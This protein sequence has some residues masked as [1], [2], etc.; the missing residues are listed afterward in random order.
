MGRKSPNYHVDVDRKSESYRPGSV[1]SSDLSDVSSVGKKSH[2]APKIVAV[3]IVSLA[4]VAILVGVTVAADMPL[5][6]SLQLSL[7]M[8]LLLLLFLLFS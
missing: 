3:I 7:F 2:N 6:L 1:T 5:S 8:V 4:I